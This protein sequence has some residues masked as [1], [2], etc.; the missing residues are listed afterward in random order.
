MN[1]SIQFTLVKKLLLPFCLLVCMIVLYFPAN[2]QEQ[3][4]KPVTVNITAVVAR[5]QL[6]FGSII[7]TDAGGTVTIDPDPGSSPHPSGVLCLGSSSSPALFQVHA[8]PGT[9]III[10]FIPPLELSLNGHPLTIKDMKSSTGSPFITTT[11]PTDV[12]I[13]GTLTVGSIIANP[14]GTYFGSIV[15][16]FT[17][18]QQ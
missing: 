1:S 14:A 10:D 11:D 9:M 17:Q 8:I 4:P 7:P 2:A 12:Y 15:V 3:P 16:K 5:Q 18:I 13:G 6:N